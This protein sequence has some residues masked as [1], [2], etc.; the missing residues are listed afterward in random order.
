MPEA[1]VDALG[2]QPGAGSGLG[3]DLDGPTDRAE[4]GEQEKDARQTEH[5]A[6]GS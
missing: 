3:R 6:D 1:R 2:H 4:G 5:G